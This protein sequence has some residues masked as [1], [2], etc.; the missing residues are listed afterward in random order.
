MMVEYSCGLVCFA[1]MKYEIFLFYLYYVRMEAGAR[2]E[3]S[4]LS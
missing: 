1:T 2:G 3:R 4:N